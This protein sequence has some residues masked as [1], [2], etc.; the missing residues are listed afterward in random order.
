MSSVLGTRC[1]EADSR[2]KL[3]TVIGHHT[4]PYAAGPK[5]LLEQPIVYHYQFPTHR[6]LSLCTQHNILGI[7]RRRTKLGRE[8]PRSLCAGRTFLHHKLR[9]Q[10]NQ[11]AELREKM[12]GVPAQVFYVPFRSRRC[13]K[14][15]PPQRSRIALPWLR[16]KMRLRSA[17]HKFELTNECA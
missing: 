1:K 7:Q 17:E 5:K 14:T 15:R 4:P 13:T 11:R 10:H 9:V 12:A 6:T 2:T 3:T 8:N 16:K